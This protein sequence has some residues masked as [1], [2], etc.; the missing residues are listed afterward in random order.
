MLSCERNKSEQN[1]QADKREN[2]KPNLKTNLF[3]SSCKHKYIQNLT[4]NSLKNE[5]FSYIFC[6]KKL[7]GAEA[8]D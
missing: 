7:R 3:F 5:D 6:Q 1:F 2:L 4:I 8:V